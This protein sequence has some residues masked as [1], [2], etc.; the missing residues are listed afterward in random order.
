MN[1]SKLLNLFAI[2]AISSTLSFGATIG[3]SFF[4]D[5]PADNSVQ[6]LDL[7]VS[8]TSTV[9]LETFSYAGGLNQA[10]TGI[11]A[12]GFAPEITVFD[13]AGNEFAFDAGAGVPACNGRAVDPVSG[14]CLDAVVYDGIS[15]PLLTLTPG[16]WTV[17]ITE[18]GNDPLGQLAIGFSEDAA[19]GNDPSFT[20][21]NAGLPG[22]MFLDPFDS[23]QRTDQWALDILGNGVSSVSEVSSAPEPASELLAAGALACIGLRR[24]RTRW[25]SLRD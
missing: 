15:Q 3:Y 4:G 21:T 19:N 5:L 2:S 25:S 22:D 24:L 8:A 14:F 18:Q 16:V 17:A 20:G 6:L 23:G 10:G 12:G 9:T 13:P 7:T 11:A 1:G